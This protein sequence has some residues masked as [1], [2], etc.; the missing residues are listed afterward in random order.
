VPQVPAPILPI[1]MGNDAGEPEIN[2]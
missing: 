2:E 1:P